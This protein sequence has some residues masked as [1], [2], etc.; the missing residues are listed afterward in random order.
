MKKTA[1]YIDLYIYNR[2]NTHVVAHITVDKLIDGK[3]I[4]A[5]ELIQSLQHYR[6]RN[7]RKAFELEQAAEQVPQIKAYIQENIDKLNAYIQKL[8]DDL[9]D[10]YGIPYCI[11]IS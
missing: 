11:R 1:N 3:R 7:N 10:V 6:D 4:P 5:S 2:G 9:R 8:P